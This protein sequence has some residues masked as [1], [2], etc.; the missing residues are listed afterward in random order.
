MRRNDTVQ[1]RLIGY[2]G[3]GVSAHDCWCDLW[4]PAQLSSS[5]PGGGKLWSARAGCLTGVVAVQTCRLTKGCILTE[6]RAKID[7]WRFEFHTFEISEVKV[8]TEC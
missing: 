8:K 5:A 2:S 3:R 6:I 7:S 1:R 4:E